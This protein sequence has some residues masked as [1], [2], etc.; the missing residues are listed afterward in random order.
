MSNDADSLELLSVV[1][2]VHHERVGQ[3][4]DDRALSLAETLL[5]VS[6]S[7]V[8]KVDRGTDLDVVAIIKQSDQQKSSFLQGT[9]RYS[10][11]RFRCAA[12]PLSH[13]LYPSSP[14]CCVFAYSSSYPGSANLR[15]NNRWK[16]EMNLVAE[17]A[18][19]QKHVRQRNVPD[20]NILVAPLVE[21]LDRAHLR[22][23]ILGQH[24]VGRSRVLDLDFPVV[25]H[26][27]AVCTC[28]RGGGIRKR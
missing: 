10:Q 9:L 6:A 17:E 14:Q 15:S 4:L 24:G 1:A 18:L 13:P 23:S 28:C 19:L 26:F 25:R 12:Q 7:G 16:L 2:A 22:K 20:L 21:E 11:F 8:R 5:G 27:D 3:T